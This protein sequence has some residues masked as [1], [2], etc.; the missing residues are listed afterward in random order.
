MISGRKTLLIAAAAA[1]LAPSAFSEVVG[2]Y[3]NGCIIDPDVLPLEG[4]N[5]QVTRPQIDRN[6]G[7]PTL[8]RFIETL[9]REAE[10]K[11]IGSVQVGD[12]SASHGGPMR[13]GH[14]SHQTGLDVDLSLKFG[15]LQKKSL[16]T[17]SFLDVVSK[18]GK[19]V[20][21]NFTWKQLEFIR[22]AASHD[23]VERIFVSPAI[24]KSICDYTGQ[25]E[26]RSFLSKIRPWFGHRGHIHV[27]LR[28]PESSPYCEKQKAVPEGDGCGEELMSWFEPPKKTDWP[29]KPQ[30]KPEKPLLPKRCQTFFVR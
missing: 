13:S 11:G 22:L 14:A 10:R 27:R 5:Y 18:D 2:S 16:G 24:K 15:R 3:S 20:N 25:N 23:E 9:S 19:S 8:I 6:Y 17:T 4:R 26:D 28:C 30:K 7:D 12:L 21:S 29:A 1:L